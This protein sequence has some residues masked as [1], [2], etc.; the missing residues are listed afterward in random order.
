[1]LIRNIYSGYLQISRCNLLR[2]ILVVCSV[3]FVAIS[4]AQ[5]GIAVKDSVALV[6]KSKE[7]KHPF[8]W[9]T[10]GLDVSKSILW[11]SNFNYSMAEIQLVSNWQ[12]NVWAALELGAGKSKVDNA[13]MQFSSTQQFMRIGIDKVLFNAEFIGDL[14]NAT[15][16]VRYGLARVSRSA[17]QLNVVDPVWGAYTDKIAATNFG[18]HWLELTGGFKMQFVKRIFIGWHVRMK[19]FLNPK[20]FAVLPPNYVAG[21]GKSDKNTAFGYNFYICYLLA[22]KNAR[23][24]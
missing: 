24:R 17:A 23:V 7:K 1:M 21:Y 3:F 13:Y 6:K 16:G 22:K 9:C 4:Y 15:I 19:T 18:A 5:P 20:T 10:V 8:T 14:D 11:I 12:P 2:L